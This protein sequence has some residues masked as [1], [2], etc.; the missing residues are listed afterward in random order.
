[1]NISVNKPIDD[2]IQLQEM[3]PICKKSKQFRNLKWQY[4]G[5]PGRPVV[6]TSLSNAGGMG[7]IPGQ[8]AKSLGASWP[9]NQN[10]KQKQYCN[11]F[12]KNL[13]NGPNFLKNLKK[14]RA[15][16]YLTGKNTGRL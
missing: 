2:L 8:G 4:E 12:N 15:V 3:L 9:K 16:L 11:K 10:I 14:K 5:L 6:K 13:K 7:S 1:M